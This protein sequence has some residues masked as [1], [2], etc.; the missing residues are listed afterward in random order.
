M[1][2]QIRLISS[3]SLKHF[4]LRVVSSSL[5]FSLLLA[6]CVPASFTVQAAS[7][8]PNVAP[9]VTAQ[10]SVNPKG[11]QIAPAS[12]NQQLQLA[13]SLK[14]NDAAGLAQFISDLYNPQSPSYKHFLTP[15]QFTNRFIDS[16]ARQQVVAFL[17]AKGFTV[18]DSGVGSVIE[19]NA[20]VGQAQTA[21]NLHIN[22]YK[23]ANGRVFYSNDVTP[24]LPLTMDSKIAGIFGLDNYTRYAPHNI[25]APPPPSSKGV[26]P[27]TGG[28]PS[29]CA[30]ATT[31][32]AAYGSYTPN[33]F[34]TAYNFDG[35]NL[36]G[37]NG[38]GQTVALYELDDY[39]DSNVSTYQS[40]FGTSVPITRHQLATY[41]TIT[42]GSG[43]TEVELDIDVLVGLA[44]G[45]SNLIVYEAANTTAA[46]IGEYQQIAND[47]SAKVVSS[48]WGGCEAYNGSILTTENTIF[49]QMAAQG[50]S[51]F[52]A[53]GDTGSEGCQRLT[54]STPNALSAGDAVSSP[55]ATGVG[56]TK[57]NLN[58][59]NTINSESVWN[60]Y[61]VSGGAG[62]GGISTQW[63]KPSYQTGPGTTNS[64]SNGKRQVPDVSADA[65]PYTGYVIFSHDTTACSSAPNNCY[66]GEGG[67]SAATPLWAAAAAITNQY[68]L[69]NSYPVLGFANPSIYS[70]FNSSASSF[71]FH[72]ITSG[73]NCYDTSCGTPNSGT[74]TYPATS[75][76]DQASGVGT[77]DAYQFALN[78]QSLITNLTANPNPA[79]TNNWV[80]ITATLKSGITTGS[81]I[82]T[83]TT[84]NTTLGTAPVSSGV[85]TIQ[86]VFATTGSHLLLATYSSGS[87]DSENTTAT[88]TE[89]IN[90]N[91][92]P[93][94]AGA[95]DEAAL[96]AALAQGGYI[97]F[98]CPNPTTIV[99]TSGFLANYRTITKNTTLDGSAY[100]QNITI[101]GNN[102]TQLFK[103]NSSINFTLTGITLTKGQDNSGNGGGAIYSN[104]NL[105]VISSTI[106]SSSSTYAGGTILVNSG[107]TTL[108]NST[109]SGNSAT[110]Y[111]G[112]IIVFGGALNV[113]NS[114]F[115]NN[116][117]TSYYGGGLLINAGTVTISNSTF[118]SNS[119]FYGGA[120]F[121]FAGTTNLYNDTIA[122]NTA[123]T[124]GGG[125]YNNGGTVNLQ[126]SIVANNSNY[127]TVNTINSLGYNLI[128]NYYTTPSGTTTGNIYNTDPALNAIANNGGPTQ[129]ML[130][131]AG[132][133]VL[134]KIPSANCTVASGVDQRG[135]PR[136]ATNAPSCDIGAVE[137]Q[138][139]SPSAVNKLSGDNQN[140]AA[141]Y[142]FAP[143]QVKVLDG[144]NNP[145]SGVAVTFVTGAGGVF[146]GSNTTETVYSDGNGIGTVS[147]LIATSTTG[148]FQVSA[149]INTGTG[150]PR[151][152]SP[153]ATAS[154]TFNENNL[155]PNAAVEL[156]AS[157]SKIDFQVPSK[158]SPNAQQTLYLKALNGNI[159]W[160]SKITYQS[161]TGWLA[162][163]AN[164]L[165]AAGFSEPLVL[166]AN[167]NS[168]TNGN[169]QATITFQ[170][171]KQ[172]NLTLS[173]QVNLQVGTG[174]YR[175]YLPF[176]ANAAN[177]FSSNL[178][179]Q[180]VGRSPATISTQFYDTAGNN[181]NTQSEACANL[182]TNAACTIS[183][184]FASNQK[185]T[186]VVL[187][188]Q[189]LSVLVA[190]NTPY[191]ASAYPV[192]AGASA[193]LVAPL[194]INQAG[195]FQTQLSIFNTAETATIA[196][197]NFYDQS[198][199]LL[200]AAT[201]N[202][203]LAPHSVAT[204]D[205]TAADS[206]LPI[207]FYGWAEISGAANSQLVGQIL[208]S[209]PDI[210]FV[211]LAN[212][213]ALSTAS[214]ATHFAP[215]IFNK[216]FGSF[217]TGTNLVNPNAN[218]V[219]ISITYY[220]S[221]GQSYTASSF[222]LAAHQIAPVYQG[223][224]TGQGLP[225]G[226]LPIGFYGSATITSVGGDLAVTVNEAGGVTK[227]NAAQSGTYSAATS[228]SNTI[229]LPIVANNGQ[230]YTTGA[231]ILNSGSNPVNVTINYYLPDG[232]PVAAST[233]SFT[234]AG[235]SSQPVYQGDSTNN[236]AT[237]Y[238]GEAVVTAPND[239]DNSL[240]VTT[241]AQSDDKFYT[242]TLPQ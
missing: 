2:K 8:P 49:Q 178:I 189:P 123:S 159:N 234:I 160:Q 152:V 203:S 92:Q 179:I 103:V 37:Y 156:T 224:T 197:V 184:F 168:L 138:Y 39:Q 54:G 11:S 112:G 120:V 127:D 147:D 53:A 91:S 44:P 215:A 171:V 78:S 175:Y 89:Q 17:Q 233:R 30:G 1:N 194:A 115:Y 225:S 162:V 16:T 95:C 209:R 126:N 3:K 121:T 23:D 163:P 114:T 58:S 100:G 47:N 105:N 165:L 150:G 12:T 188:D 177:G 124:T 180:N 45:L 129:T 151:L 206:N 113:Q 64:F 154:Q 218:P 55:F 239:A 38:A 202:L 93:I 51:L 71:V 167:A 145:A 141:N 226:G 82:F 43:E 196:T 137:A 41:G 31:A 111:G 87:T 242:Y 36:Q 211:A 227:N 24:Q 106:S 65:D 116:S 125:I 76:Y 146:G 216:A 213:P 181:L 222:T 210:H 128:K 220:D 170:D 22:N 133:P 69:A 236:L 84:T 20:S 135:Y 63:A 9:A 15:A 173:V 166:T 144:S 241:N 200:P 68:L 142:T 75:G 5:L 169:Y 46:Y 97:T 187:S 195:G 18:N 204:L 77:F 83:D 10:T 221:A 143:L 155:G 110:N 238:Y 174:G 217:V 14:V 21:F 52:V 35:L 67:T 70:I 66:F 136:P 27:H 157:T 6:V 118:N 29:G 98:D 158:A 185:G 90:A 212:T 232:S 198:G 72:D 57:L 104:G 164:G 80:T 109:I 148:A 201:K 117:V 230:G 42:I 81:V 56:G 101:S 94:V 119:A 62:G 205:Q 140:V 134:D 240:I 122:N 172:S 26:Q 48:S 32:A 85:T 108:T 182:S 13:V 190:E 193:N 214:S 231:T 59:G 61:S 88:Y 207:G 34:K 183:N 79:L 149:T 99:V 74:A 102:A 132:S 228:G 199:A 50:Q 4:L 176:L 86:A 96:N 229:G 40:C 107:T 33:E 130:P 73:D 161:G 192:A 235:H 208:E 131:Q 25:I 7:L 60:E 28:T 186:G 237:G 223:A 153:K 219:T 191:G 19:F 139:N